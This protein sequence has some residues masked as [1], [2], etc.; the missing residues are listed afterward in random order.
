ML[1]MRS[2]GVV[3]SMRSLPSA[4]LRHREPSEAL[5]H[6]TQWPSGE[7]WAR[8][9]ALRFSSRAINVEEL[10]SACNSSICW[11]TPMK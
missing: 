10:G 4:R 8:A 5:S 11:L 3:N 9:A 2:G 6:A 1:N 7:Y